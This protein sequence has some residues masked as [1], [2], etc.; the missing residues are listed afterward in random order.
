MIIKKSELKLLPANE[1]KRIEVTK[2]NFDDVDASMLTN[3]MLDRM[4]Y[5]IS[6]SYL[7]QT[8]DSFVCLIIY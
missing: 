3:I 2:F 1:L 8:T 4:I 6:Q 5:Q 7:A